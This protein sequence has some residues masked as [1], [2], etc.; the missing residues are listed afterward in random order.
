MPNYSYICY[1]CKVQ[2]DR[3]YKWDNKH[4][5]ICEMCDS[6]LVALVTAPAKTSGRWGDNTGKH[7]VNG[8]Y[9]RGL[10]ATYY[11]SMDREALCKSKGLIPLEDVGSSH[12]VEDRM[13]SDRSILDQQDKVLQTYNNKVAEYGGD[14]RGKIKAIEEVFP[15]K[16]CLGESGNVGT[17]DLN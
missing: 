16:D 2:S 11:N 10:G 15:A 1:T 12:W 13:A 9:D 6:T 7:G 8:K 4:E 14:E 17:M 3:L 5:Q